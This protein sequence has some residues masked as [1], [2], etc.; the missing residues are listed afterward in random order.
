MLKKLS[1]YKHIGSG[2]HYFLICPTNM[3]ATQDDYVKGAT[4]INIKTH[5][6][7]NRSADAITEKFEYIRPMNGTEL[8]NL[9]QIISDCY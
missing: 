5:C 8:N 3:T 6:C 1:V 7:F 9:V 4:Y 2:E